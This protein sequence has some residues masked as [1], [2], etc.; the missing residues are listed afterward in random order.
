MTQNNTLPAEDSSVS[1]KGAPYVFKAG[2]LRHGSIVEVFDH[3]NWVESI[4]HRNWIFPSHRSDQWFNENHRP[5]KLTPDILRRSNFVLKPGEW[6]QIET[7]VM[8]FFVSIS[9]NAKLLHYDYGNDFITIPL[10]FEHFHRLQ[11]FISCFGKDLPLTPTT[12]T[13]SNN[14]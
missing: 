10:P 1:V 7:G 3:Q 12:N 13:P 9:L 11:D 2:E 5:I 8:D 6:W 14:K 4:L